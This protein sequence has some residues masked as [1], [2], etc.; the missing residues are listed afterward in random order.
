MNLPSLSEISGKAKMA[1]GRFPIT[2]IWVVFGSFYCMYL[3]EYAEYD[4]PEK[5]FRVVMTLILGIS[6]LIGSQFFIEQ[7]KNPKVWQAL[8]LVVLALLVGFFFYLPL[9]HYYDSNPEYFIRFFLFLIAGHLFLFVAPFISKWD[10]N[11]YWNYLKTM[12]TSILRSGFFSG[13]LYIGLALALAAIDALFDVNIPG[14]R[15]GQTF[16]FCLGIVNTLVYLSD[17]PKNI[18][19]QTQ[20]HFQKAL[21]VLVKYILIP[22]IILYL[23]ILYAYSFKILIDWELP[24]GWVSYLVIA[25]SLLGFLIQVII[26]PI[27]KQIQSWTI[28][29]FYPFFYLLLVPLIGLLFVAIFRRIN[30]YGIT[31][32][33][34]F[35]LAIAF[36]IL[37]IA[38]YLLVS[39]KKSLKILPISLFFLAIIAS[40]GFWG[41]IS[42][43]TKSQVDQ[44]NQL[45][46]KA[47]NQDKV[48]SSDDYYRLED[49]LEY[50]EE[51]KA[52]SKLDKITG[53]T[54]EQFRDTIKQENRDQ[55][56]LNT[57][58]ILD[59][60]AIKIDSETIKE[61]FRDNTYFSYY[62]NWN[63]TV[64]LPIEG[65]DTFRTISLNNADPTKVTATDFYTKYDEENI[66]ITFYDNA[67]DS[68]IDVLNLKS[69]LKKFSKLGNNL[70]KIPIEKL[71]IGKENKVLSYKIVLNEFSF[72][73][74]QDTITLNY[75]T[76]F[77][78]SKKN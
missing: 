73:K 45:Y 78:F 10:K 57:S 66:L 69:E 33:R 22:L 29:K 44:F 39:K 1:I 25:L 13:I 46:T 11:A 60:L 51:R 20:I 23:A 12:A 34:Y 52:V 26:N 41:A 48:L 14:K 58:Q 63:N 77:L 24:K 49:I 18:F 16:I 15:Y 54:F 72:R 28:N 53:L 17:F 71:I 47:L 40:F 76:G 31:E 36:W 55:G 4:F 56:W 32:N 35:V 5:H 59:T 65:Y 62:R 42:V 64:V 7:Q 8:K 2:S 37:G 43:S 21:E 3:L 30:D 61:S 68:I 67:N 70:D 27:Q 19:E 74:E 9:E 38:V 50:L 6:W 75:L